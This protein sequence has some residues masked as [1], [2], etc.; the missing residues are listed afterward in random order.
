MKGQILMM[1]VQK[2][3]SNP[4][5]TLAIQS[6]SSYCSSRGQLWIIKEKW[7]GVE[8]VHEYNVRLL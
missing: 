5:N 7:R 8:I 3:K 2:D 4:Q 1:A 6:Q